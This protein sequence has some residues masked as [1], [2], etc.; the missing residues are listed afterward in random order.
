DLRGADEAFLTST[1]K[2]IVP[3]RRCDGW[4]IRHGRPGPVTLRLLEFYEALV[5]AETNAGAAPG[6]SR[7]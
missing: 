1:L 5:Q 2:G 3:V 7:R 6:A 4:P